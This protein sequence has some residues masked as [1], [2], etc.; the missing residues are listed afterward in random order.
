[1]SLDIAS[2]FAGRTVF[3]TGGTGFVGKVLLYKILSEIPDIKRIYLLCRGKKPRRGTKVL[4]PQQRLEQEVLGSPCFDPLKNRIGKEAWADLCSRI[5]AVNGDIT[6]DGF[7]ISE[8][9]MERLTNEVQLIVHL[10]ATVNF[11]EKL[12]SAIQMNTLGGLRALMIGKKCKKLEAMVHVSTCYV[13]FQRHGRENPNEEKIYPLEFDPEAMVKQVLSLHEE[14]VEPES[15]RLLKAC[16]FPNTYTFTKSIGEQLI[17]KYM[18][19]VPLV[20]VRPSIIGAS[21]KDPVPGWVDALTAAGGLL[22]TACLGV[23]RELQLGEDLLADVIPVDFVCNIIIKALFKTQQHYQK[24]RSAGAAVGHTAAAGK[25]ITAQQQKADRLPFVYQAAT[26]SVNPM[27]WGRLYRATKNFMDSTPRKHPKALSRCDVCLTTNATVYR[28]RHTVLRYFPYLALRAV[29][30]LPEP[31]GSEQMRKKVNQLGRAVRRADILNSEFH[32]FVVH[33][34]VYD[35]TNSLELNSGLNQK[36]RKAFPFD[37]L[38]IDWFNYVQHYI[39]GLMNYIVKDTGDLRK[40]PAPRASQEMFMRANNKEKTPTNQPTEGSDRKKRLLLLLLFSAGEM[41]EDFE[42]IINASEAV[43]E[44]QPV[45]DEEQPAAEEEQRGE[46]SV[47][48]KS[49][50]IE[51]SAPPDEEN[52]HLLQKYGKEPVV[53]DEAVVEERSGA[54]EDRVVIEKQVIGSFCNDVTC[55]SHCIQQLQI[56]ICA[57]AFFLPFY[58]FEQPRFVEYDQSVAHKALSLSMGK[59]ACRYSGRNGLPCQLRLRRLATAASVS[60]PRYYLSTRFLTDTL[61]IPEELAIR[62]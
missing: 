32:D 25:V 38:D 41:N 5:K 49:V 56:S 34:W 39:Y 8:A 55:F 16:N 21:F 31:V 36:S 2:A 19:D 51:V 42:M 27:T 13:N 54:D 24:K 3:M 15:K 57:C 59:V 30:A 29:A 50:I 12:N 26:S 22:L 58:S 37:P 62:R 10:A 7:G 4:S 1:M 20:I 43:D 45:A 48:G 14:E 47:L 33:E 35:V 9:D 28:L 53:G 52:E 61:T 44:E 17:Q 23:V 18:D 60:T 6:A 40:P 46:T 11:N